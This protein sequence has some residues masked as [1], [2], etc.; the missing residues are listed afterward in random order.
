M[1]MWWSIH[2]SVH[3]IYYNIHVC[4]TWGHVY[5]MYI[6]RYILYHNVK[7]VVLENNMYTGPELAELW[8]NACHAGPA[9]F[10]CLAGHRINMCALPVVA[11]QQTWDIDP[12]LLWCWPA[13]FDVGPA[14]KQHWVDGLS[15]VAG[16]S[17]KLYFKV[18]CHLHVYVTDAAKAN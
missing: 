18:V 14:S 1:Q 13:V 3:F 6:C 8:H 7:K 9:L 15:V 4:M 10:S 5:N 17:L 16:L 11:A 12:M 2:I